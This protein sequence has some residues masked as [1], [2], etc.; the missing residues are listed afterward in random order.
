MRRSVRVV[1][2]GL[3]VQILCLVS[4][5]ASKPLTTTEKR[6]GEPEAGKAL[7]YFIRPAHQTASARTMFLYSDKKLL[8]TIDNN[9]YTFAH[10]DPGS[11]LFWTNWT[12]I[13][14]R[15]EL[16]PDRTYYFRV[17]QT[18]VTVDEK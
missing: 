8:G 5:G 18:F 3:V 10:V 2:L 1:T 7:V 12:A 15:L 9:S 13:S 6:Y 14:E 16:V 4:A 11:H 17:W